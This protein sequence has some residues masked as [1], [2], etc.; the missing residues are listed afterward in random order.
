[1]ADSDDNHDAASDGPDPDVYNDVPNDA[2]LEHW[3]VVDR[4]LRSLK[5]RFTA[6][7]RRLTAQMTKVDKLLDAVEQLICEQPQLRSGGNTQLPPQLKVSPPPT[8]ARP[9]TVVPA[10]R[11][12]PLL[13]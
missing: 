1:M 13:A 8:C 9:A 11:P 6:F 12:P 3:E 4:K 7:G 5:R 10:F 2:P